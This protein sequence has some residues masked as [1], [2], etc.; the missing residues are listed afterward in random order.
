MRSAK[1]GGS[2]SFTVVWGSL[3][4]LRKIAEDPRTPDALDR[5]IVEIEEI[6]K[7]LDGAAKLRHISTR[8]MRR[9]EKKLTPTAIEDAVGI[10]PIVKHKQIQQPQGGE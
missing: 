7:H 9:Y 4:V 1:L 10:F 8:L 2:T 5:V 6:R 3:R